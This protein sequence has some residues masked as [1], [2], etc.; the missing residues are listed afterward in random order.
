MVKDNSVTATVAAT[1]QSAQEEFSKDTQGCFVAA[2]LMLSFAGSLCWG[3]WQVSA[4]I[5][6]TLNSNTAT[7]T[8][9]SAAIKDALQVLL[10]IGTLFSPL[11]AFVLGY[12]FNHSQSARIQADKSG[13]TSDD[14]K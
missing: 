1:A 8:D 7:A 4:I 6:T 11:L 14:A 2:V 13:V 10:T 3:F 5:G 9:R 12:Y